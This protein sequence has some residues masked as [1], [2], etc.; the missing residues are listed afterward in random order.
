MAAD[1]VPPDAPE[2]L[3]EALVDTRSR[4]SLV[5]LIPLVAV[6]AA[7]W[8]GYRTYVEQGPLV[9]ISFQT[10]EGLEAGKTRVR[11]K[12]VEIGQVETIELSRDLSRVVVHARLSRNVEGFL[13][14]N[15]RFWVVRPRFSGGQV[16][17]LTTL[18]GGAYIGV[19]LTDAGE[20]R[21][22]FQGLESPPVVTATEPGHTFT[23]HAATLGSLAVGSPVHYRDIEVGRV[24]AYKLLEPEAGSDAA[25]GVEIQVFIHAPHH[26]KVRSNTRFWHASG[27]GLSLD[28]SGIRVNTESLAALLLGGI[29]YGTPPDLDPGAAVDDD[30]V[31]RLYPNRQLAEERQ[32]SRR[33]TWRLEFEGSVRGLNPGAPVEFRGIRIGQVREVRLEFD[34]PSQATR[35]PVLVEIEPER[36]GLSATAEPAAERQL[37]DRL[38]AG[39][40]RAQ[41]KTGSLLTGALYVDLD[42][43][44][45]DPPRPIAWDAGSPLLPT[46]PTPLDELRSLLTRLSRL[47]LDRMG[48]DLSSSLSALRDTLEQTRAVLQ[49]LDGETAPEL[50]RTLVQTR[51]TLESAQKVLTP[52]SP[53]QSEAQRVL[54]ELGAAARSLRIMAD[55]L[56]RH[57]EALIR[58]KAEQP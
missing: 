33:E 29:S 4:V 23:L 54:H 47:P 8:L 37:W 19:D 1:P 42:F 12:D 28:A 5:W 27:V 21:R 24:I 49:R 31:F 41:L 58:G 35:I 30:T 18:V 56:E 32:Y 16:S 48:E 52:G 7:A 11:Y 20:S 55:Y 45:D 3:P 10:A 43:Y 53:L 40:L 50:T 26:A 44:P 34:A 25:A 39:G 15:T 51:K 2:E 22:D 38:V 9:S 57:P 13:T 46:V 6:L 36:L 17:G 14:E